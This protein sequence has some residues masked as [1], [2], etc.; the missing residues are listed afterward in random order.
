[1]R[2]SRIRTAAEASEYVSNLVAAY[3]SIQEVWL[4][5]SRANG[6][7]TPCS[8]WDYMVFANEATLAKLRG[9]SRF[10]C[11]GIDLMVVTD[12]NQFVSPLTEYARSKSGSLSD[13]DGGWHWA[14]LSPTKAMYRA[15]KD[16]LKN[17]I[18]VD[19]QG[20]HFVDDP[21]MLH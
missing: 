8:D 9:D 15:T 13:K 19:V 7:A 14:R 6:S 20:S 5:G 10:H 21:L 2:G 11:S 12:G 4:F 16:S 18:A 1:M 3:P 17:N